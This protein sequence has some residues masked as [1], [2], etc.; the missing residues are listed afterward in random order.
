M[1]KFCHKCYEVGM[2]M[3]QTKP[4]TPWSNVA[5]GT[6]WELKCGAGQE[7]AKYSCPSKLWDRCL[8]LEACIRS[9]TALDKYEL[10]G[11]VS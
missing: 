8:E 7:M 11:Q 4:Y 10:Q 3:K 2:C 5:E 9:H 6:I 1:G